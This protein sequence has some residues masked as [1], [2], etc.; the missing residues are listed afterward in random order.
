[1]NQ[2]QISTVAHLIAEPVR[3]M[4][5]IMLLDDEAYSAGALAEAAGVTAQIASFHLAKLREGGLASVE[6]VLP[7]LRACSV[8]V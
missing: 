4:I 7:S 2:L 5:L 1:M 3:S 6:Q 8:M